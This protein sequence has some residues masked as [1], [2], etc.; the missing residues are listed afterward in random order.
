MAEPAADEAR[1]T[2]G[3]AIDRIRNLDFEYKPNEPTPHGYYGHLLDEPSPLQQEYLDRR[4]RYFRDFLEFADRDIR[5]ADVLEAGSG[6]GLGL[7][8]L[9]S[10]GARKVRGIEIV[11]WMVDFACRARDVLPDELRDRTEPTVGSVISLPYE[12]AEFD[13]VLSLEAISH[14]LD[15]RPFLAEAHRVLRPGGVL[16]VS[17]GNNGLNPITRRKTVD[18]W[19]GHEVDPGP[20]STDT[21][22]PW[23]FVP[24]RQ[25]II[26][27]AFPQLDRDEAHRLALHTSGMVREQI[28]EAVSRYVEDGVLPRGPYRRGELSIHPEM[29]IVMERLFNPYALKREIESFGFRCKLR[30]HWAGASGKLTH[31]VADRVLGSLGPLTICSARGF[32]I[33]AYKQ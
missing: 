4:I 25:Q 13:I 28:V 12:E 9:A 26:A 22:N 24:K 2:Y 3:G 21:D 5:G 15:Y 31:R 16:V 29:E 7:V 33:A 23:L 19:A 6:F 18:I 30:G 32:R 11:P 27:D 20:V 8:L 17:D 1:A 10:L 14:Y